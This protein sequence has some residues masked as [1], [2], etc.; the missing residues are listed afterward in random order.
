MP[1]GRKDIL[2]EFDMLSVLWE[3]FKDTR[4]KT[5]VKE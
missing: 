5:E 3:C 1:Y 4:S 2:K